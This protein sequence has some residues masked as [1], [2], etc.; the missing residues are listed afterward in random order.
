MSDSK[1]FAFLVSVP[2]GRII[3]IAALQAGLLTSAIS[4]KCNQPPD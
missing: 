1:L 4:Q 3:A 2:F